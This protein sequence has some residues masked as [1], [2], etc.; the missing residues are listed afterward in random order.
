MYFLYRAFGTVISL[1]S[2][3]RLPVDWSV[4]NRGTIT[5]L[6]TLVTGQTGLCIYLNNQNPQC[7]Q[8]TI[9]YRVDPWR[10][11]VFKAPTKLQRLKAATL[12]TCMSGLI[13][14]NDHKKETTLMIIFSVIII[15][16]LYPEILSTQLVEQFLNVLKYCFNGIYE[17]ITTIIH[18]LIFTHGLN[19]IHVLFNYQT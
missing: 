12:R 16:V 8:K 18:Y 6:L 1:S 11:R 13:W 2:L 10:P 17:N 4:R 5:T 3:L 14:Y 15:H 9:D 7:Q 19:A